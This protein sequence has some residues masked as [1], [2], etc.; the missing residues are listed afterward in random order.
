M[1]RKLL[2]VHGVANRNADDF[3]ETTRYLEEQLVDTHQVVRF[4]WGDLGGVSAGLADIIPGPAAAPPR[5]STKANEAR[6]TE[7]ILRHVRP[8]WRSGAAPFSVSTDPVRDEVR[9]GV[10]QSQHLKWIEDEAILDAVGEAVQAALDDG[11]QDVVLSPSGPARSEPFFDLL[12]NT[13]QTEKLPAVLKALDAYIGRTAGH[14]GGLLS[15]VVRERMAEPVAL[16][17]G[18]L[19]AAHERR[20]VIQERLFEMLASNAEG[21][22]LDESRPI[23]VL[24]H[25]LGGLIVLGAVLGLW[26]GKRL[27]INHLVTIGSAPALFH[28]MNPRGDLPTYTGKPL[29]RPPNVLRWTNLW[30]PLDVLSFKV[31]P[32]FA[33]VKDMPISSTATEIVGAKG[34]LHSTY[35][36]DS[37]LVD[38]LRSELDGAG[39]RA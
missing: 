26:Q 33:D 36:T 14:A 6:A 3:A 27:Y 20:D 5:D 17:L 7:R 19:I 38:V 9:A 30:H 16:S 22:G 23:D 25:S 11:T 4:F 34:W 1:R 39:D 8:A 15:R 29:Q 37:E 35:W 12:G 32:V 24:C 21:Y 2:V 31:A 18:D 13:T 28:I 10:A